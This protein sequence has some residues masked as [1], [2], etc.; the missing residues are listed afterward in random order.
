MAKSAKPFKFRDKWRASPTLSSGKRVTRDF[1]RYDDAAQWIAEQLAHANAAHLPELGGPTTA[2]LADALV[3]YA[4]N[5]TVRKKGALSELN[6]INHYLEGA[7]KQRLRLRINE[8]GGRYLE[9]YTGRVAP[10]AWHQHNEARRAARTQTYRLIEELATKRCAAISTLH[11]RQ[12]MTAMET[13]ELSPSTIQKEIAL[14]KHVF[15]TA[16]SE[17]NWT[18]LKNP[19]VGIKLGTSVDRF[20]FITTEN[21]VAL[22]KALSECDNPY[23]WPLVELSLETTMRRSSLLAMQ[24]DMTDL[25]G[26]VAVVSS[27]TGQVAIPLTQTAVAVL[28]GLPRDVSGRV[29]PMTPNAVACAWNGV[30]IKAC[31]PALQFRDLRHVGATDFAR[32]GVGAHQLKAILGHKTTAMANRYVNLVANDILETMDRTQPVT[33]AALLPPSATGSAVRLLH[34]KKAARLNKTAATSDNAVAGKT[35][36]TATVI[37]ITRPR[38]A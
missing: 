2:T 7:G 13:E 6:R 22:R 14:L 28:Q 37:N 9:K 15:N 11:L 36:V 3:F 21:R 35:P 1:D 38:T 30:R 33:T 20:V 23:F 5:Y 32:R 24:W 4:E 25:D 27:K 18:G 10:A 16:E 26:R 34:Q 29:F 12:L 17:W 8:T 19:C 31:L